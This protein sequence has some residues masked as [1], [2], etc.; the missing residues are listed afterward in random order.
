MS[1]AEAV[2][3]AAAELPTSL[4]NRIDTDGDCWLWTAG[5]NAGGYAQARHHGKVRRVHIVV[6]EL[7]VGDVPEGL[8]LDH[9][10][11]NKRCVRPH[12]EHVNA[13][14]HQEN[15]RRHYARAATCKRGHPWTE[16]NTYRRPSTG[17]RECRGCNREK[18][19]GRRS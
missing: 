7:L 5:T 17:R 3:W 18:Q 11:A 6:Y 15:T 13:C 14:T 8:E 1:V 4:A 19:A 10:C 12:P 9:A 16:A 2:D